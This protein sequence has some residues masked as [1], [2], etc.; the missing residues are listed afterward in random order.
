[1]DIKYKILTLILMLLNRASKKMHL[2]SLQKPY[3]YSSQKVKEIDTTEV[4][5]YTLEKVFFQ[6]KIKYVVFQVV[7]KNM[8]VAIDLLK[9]LKSNNNISNISNTKF[10]SFI[11]K[12]LDKFLNR[13]VVKKQQE[14]INIFNI[15]KDITNLFIKLL[16]ILK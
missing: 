7:N 3:K 14:R 15:L 8:L 10:E 9:E 6:E 4:F 13:Q 16:S 5:T 12:P 2:S 1:M 11:T